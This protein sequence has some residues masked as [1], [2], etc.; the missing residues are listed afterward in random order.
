MRTVKLPVP[1]P[2]SKTV[3]E[4]CKFAFSTIPFATSG[5]FK[6]CWPS[7]LLKRGATVLEAEGFLET[8]APGAILD[9]SLWQVTPGRLFKIKL[10]LE[11]FK[12]ECL[13][14][15]SRCLIF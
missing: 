15:Y 10:S 5:F 6:M 14:V 12:S 3:S 9:I 4:A 11:W 8:E 1:G 13:D 2:I 7:S